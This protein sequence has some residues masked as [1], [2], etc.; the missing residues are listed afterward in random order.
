MNH[1]SL[2]QN[3]TTPWS[4]GWGWETMA[5]KGKE[6]KGLMDYHSSRSWVVQPSF[7]PQSKEKDY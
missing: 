5:Q 7:D 2:A 4:G 3:T 6:S 1:P